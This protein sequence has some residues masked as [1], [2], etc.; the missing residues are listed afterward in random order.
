M[1]HGRDWRLTE[2]ARTRS[3]LKTPCERENRAAPIN[4]EEQALEQDKLFLQRKKTGGKK[5]RGCQL[6]EDPRSRSI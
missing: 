3:P 5:Q 6:Q 4:V 1:S 2:R